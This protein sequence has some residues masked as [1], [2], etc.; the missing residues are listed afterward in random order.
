MRLKGNIRKINDADLRDIL[1][2]PH[3]NR[4]GQYIC[5]CP[6]CGKEKHFYISKETQLFDCKRCGEY[7]SI[8]KLLKHL[9]KS[10]LLGGS[11]VEEKEV[12]QSIRSMLANDDNFS[13]A[14]SKELPDV[15]M[16]VGW[17]VFLNS[18]QYLKNRGIT[19]K[20]CVRY[21]IGGTNLL[22]KMKDYVIIPVTD[23]GKIKGYV[24]RWGGKKVPEG[25][26]RYNNSIGTEFS[27]L[28]FGYDEITEN[29]LT[30]I[31]VE[32]IFDK[33]AV[34][35]FFELWNGEE[36]KSCCTFG[37]KISD[38]QI[39]K[40][41][42]KGV[43]NVILLYDFDAI[44]EIKKYGVELDNYFKTSITYTYKK[45][46]DECNYEEA[47]EVFSNLRKPKE[48]NVDIIGKFK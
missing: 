20:D 33:I 26:L 1:I 46:I 19:R 28:L 14:G 2:N 13:L 27:S 15:I 36:V 31:L 25:R 39:S 44:K 22:R 11:T 3:L 21:K 42:Q 38:E 29:T 47:L 34:D 7:G 24:G 30:V 35:K 18:T 41:I 37:K 17:K 9:G 4:R 45:D 6:F 10:Y 12:I 23:G 8:Y 5:D 43:T 32:G 40:L 48:F 16:P